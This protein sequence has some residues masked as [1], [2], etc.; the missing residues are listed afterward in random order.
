MKSLNSI[1][2]EKII[3]ASSSNLDLTNSTHLEQVLEVAEKILVSCLTYEAIEA[4][5]NQLISNKDA[6]PLMTHLATKLA[7]SKQIVR[8][9][10]DAVHVT[11][12]FAVYKE[13]NRIR[14]REEHP[15]GENFLLRKIK[16]L[17]WLF[18]GAPNFSWDMT[19]VDDGDPAKSGKIAEEILSEKYDG[20]NVKVIFLEE[21]IRQ[22]IPVTAPMRST[23]ESRKGGS[24]IYGM[25]DATQQFKPNHIII[26]TDA[27]LSTHLGQVGLLIDPIIKQG[28]DAAVGSRREKESIVIKKGAR[29]DRGKLFIYLWKRMLPNLNYIVDTQCG[30]KAFTAETVARIIP[31]MLEKQFAFDIELLLKAE[32]HHQNSISKVPIAWID[33]EAASTTTDIQPYLSMLQCIAQMYKKYLPHNIQ[34]QGFADFVIS[35]DKKKWDF[36]LEN[37]PSEITSREPLDFNEYQGVRVADLK[38]IIDG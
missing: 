34:A 5:E 19:V 1:D 15:H 11:I 17:N 29:N 14:T 24:I 16:Q 31:D 21:A 22:G 32:L 20:D 8:N 36:L 38:S 27:D 18:D 25:W 37:I 10:S 9:I 7:K 12:V 33:S 6:F 2:Y 13:H 4:F 3:H 35:L 28:K 26:F 30:F 23:D